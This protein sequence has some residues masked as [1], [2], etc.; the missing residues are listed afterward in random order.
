MGVVLALEFTACLAKVEAEAAGL[1]DHG[2]KPLVLLPGK[3][4]RGLPDRDSS[5]PCSLPPFSL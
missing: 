5:G 3:E 1:D 4:P 2:R